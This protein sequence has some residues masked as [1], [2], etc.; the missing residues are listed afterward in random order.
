MV[1]KDRRS[2]FYILTKVGNGGS[3]RSL[4][5]RKALRVANHFPSNGE[6]CVMKSWRKSLVFLIRCLYTRQV[7]LEVGDHGLLS[8][9]ERGEPD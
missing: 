1:K 2:T 5:P 3:K 8:F 9:G 6:D 4:F 7:L